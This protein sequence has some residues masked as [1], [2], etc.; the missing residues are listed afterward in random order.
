MIP[1]ASTWWFSSGA[2]WFK[3]VRSAGIIPGSVAWLEMSN[4]VLHVYMRW[5]VFGVS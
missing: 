3:E 4:N 5:L 2:A 1:A